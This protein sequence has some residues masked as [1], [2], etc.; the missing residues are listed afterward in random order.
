MGRTI[1]SRQAIEATDQESN[2]RNQAELRNKVKN[3]V[4]WYNKRPS[5]FISTFGSYKHAENW[6]LKRDGPVY[7]LAFDTNMLPADQLV[8]QPHR[9]GVNTK[10]SGDEYLFFR[11]IPLCAL[12]QECSAK[13]K[14]FPEHEPRPRRT[15]QFHNCYT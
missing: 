8:F 4:N 6:A 14:Q 11:E 1:R 9:L 12:N 2:I 7:L 13:V 15:V 10:W 3:H 5:M